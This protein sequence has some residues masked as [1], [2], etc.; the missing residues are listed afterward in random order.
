[1]ANSIDFSYAISIS[2]NST[3]GSALNNKLQDS[4]NITDQNL[5]NS[6][7]GGQVYKT[8]LKL[9]PN[10]FNSL[11]LANLG[12][13]FIKS[14]YIKSS[15]LLEITITPNFD[16]FSS[17]LLNCYS[18]L[19]EFGDDNNN[20]SSVNKNIKIANKGQTISDVYLLI[21]GI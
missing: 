20:V 19:I 13:T 5:N 9:E 10:T 2:T 16:N 1:M 12:I 15:E 11:N 4:T 7:S 18:T 6:I 21:V 3:S 8:N 17:N 14:L